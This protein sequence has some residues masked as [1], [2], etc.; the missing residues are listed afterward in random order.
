MA[1]YLNNLRV[2]NAENFTKLAQS[3]TTASL[4]LSF[5]KNDE[6][7]NDLNPPEVAANTKTEYDVWFNMIGAKKITSYDVRQVI[8]RIDW[9][10]NTVYNQYDDQNTSLFSANSNFY[11]LTSNNRVY[12][13]LDN[14]NGIKS[15]I[16]PNGTST[17]GTIKLADGYTWKYMYAL[18]D[19]DKLRF[20]IDDY[21]PVRKL[22]NDDG[23]DQWDIQQN[24]TK[25][26][27]HSIV[28]TNG[29][30][31]YSNINNIFVTIV[32][33]GTGAYATASVNTVSNVVNAIVMVTEGSGY[34][35]ASAYIF[36]GGGANATARVIISPFGGHGSN[37]TYELGAS[38]VL[39]NTRLVGNQDNKYPDT[40]EFRQ[41][42]IVKDPFNHETET[43]SSNTVVSQTL[44]LSLYNYAIGVGVPTD[45]DV[46]EEV[47]QGVSVSDYS[48]KARVVDWDG[49]NNIVSLTQTLG[50]PI[51][52]ESLYGN[53]STT[54][55][56]VNAV[57]N[58]D[59]EPY[60]GQILYVDNFAPITKD[61]NQTEDIKVLIKF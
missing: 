16:E 28:L 4:Y 30:S 15:N 27:I 19:E 53:D 48:F 49:T 10:A 51:L 42:A 9:T 18:S 52:T 5:G 57:I 6:W 56:I 41:V 46:G 2:F 33:D 45:Y 40:T 13:C 23:S 14:K 58:P 3:N 34:T 12:K 39:V 32:G 1:N 43:V 44:N 24:A 26:A 22:E 60:T 35:R 7:P 37:P 38:T 54:N 8:R 25:G 59:L 50:T 61:P 31:N 11:V 55:K 29:G 47:Y 36:G 21:I 17:T 20:T